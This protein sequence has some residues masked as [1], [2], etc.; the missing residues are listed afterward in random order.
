MALKKKV[1]KSTTKKKVK[2]IVKKDT[3]S[4]TKEQPQISVGDR[5]QVTDEHEDATP[6]AQDNNMAIGAVTGINVGGKLGG[7]IHV[8]FSKKKR[9]TFLA[10]ELKLIET[11]DDFQAAFQTEGD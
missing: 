11:L 9:G 3:K 7:Q 10:H 6:I 4:A 1:S 8:Y 2:K 5:V